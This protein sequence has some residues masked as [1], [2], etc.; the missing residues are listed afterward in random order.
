MRKS[1]IFSSPREKAERKGVSDTCRVMSGRQFVD[2][3]STGFNDSTFS[4]GFD[5]YFEFHYSALAKHNMEC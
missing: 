5:V 2:T 3:E 4:I 1:Q